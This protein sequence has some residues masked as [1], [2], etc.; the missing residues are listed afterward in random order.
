VTFDVEVA[1]KTLQEAGY[2]DHALKLA[3]THGEHDWYLKIQLERPDPDCHDALAYITELLFRLPRES[4][5]KFI[6]TYARKILQHIPE[7]LV[8]LLAKLC[9][10][11]ITAKEFGVSEV[12]SSQ[13]QRPV[14][15]PQKDKPAQ[16]QQKLLV[17]RYPG[18]EEEMRCLDPEEFMS[19]FT[20]QDRWLRVF[21]DSVHSATQ[22]GVMARIPSARVTET[23]LEVMLQEWMRLKQ[24][25]D[26]GG[27][28]PELKAFL[29]V[30]EER[31]MGLLDEP[32]ATYDEAQAL[33]LV[34][35]VLEP[36]FDNRALMQLL[37]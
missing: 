16:E 19:V 22:S 32:H 24:R 10:G 20:D 23:L 12:P 4:V 17:R 35:V 36:A 27:T 7:E 3:R 34:Q 14:S 18:Q 1:L 15:S 26:E 2:H 6:K 21:L 30:Q 37:L 28:D 31:I 9:T 25:A 5:L 11:N 29:A 13:T 8:G 33:L